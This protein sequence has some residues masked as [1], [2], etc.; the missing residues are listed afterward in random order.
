M[1]GLALGQG[2]GG[3]GGDEIGI[4]AENASTEESSAN[5]KGAG[6]EALAGWYF[7][8]GG[9]YFS[10]ETRLDAENCAVEISDEADAENYTDSGYEKRGGREYG[11]RLTSRLAT[12]KDAS[13]GGTLAAGYG[14]F[15][16][17][18]C[19]LGVEIGSDVRRTKS[20]KISLD[21]NAALGNDTEATA[22]CGPRP[23]CFKP[24]ADI[25]VGAYVNDIGALV[26][27]TAGVRY[28]NLKIQ[29]PKDSYGAANI[30]P[31][32]GLGAEKAVNQKLSVRME[33]E[34]CFRTRKKGWLGC[35]G[36]ADPTK[37]EM[38][39]KTDDYSVRFMIAYHI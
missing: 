15:V 16:A 7:G 29:G 13:L 12:K 26:Y 10:Q 5:C 27:L 24:R 25:R 14:R 22:S 28:R 34:Y 39:A 11:K 8:L 31:A 36:G 3:V 38:N 35:E 37:L 21:L 32:V 4:S 33:G 6:K 20:H 9:G 2:S 17:G 18:C 1:P 23:D 19:Y 30:A